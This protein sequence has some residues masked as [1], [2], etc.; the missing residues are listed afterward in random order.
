[1]LDLIKKLASLVTGIVHG[2][3]FGG[4]IS[5]G[6]SLITIPTHISL[7]IG[8]VFGLVAFVCHW[9]D[10]NLPA[11]KQ[12]ADRVEAIESKL[13]G[14][15][16]ITPW[17]D[18]AIPQLPPG[19]PISLPTADQIAQAIAAQTAIVATPIVPATTAVLSAAVVG[20]NGKTQ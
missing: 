9:I 12:I 1:M 11:D 20:A 2:G 17:T 7:V 4:I 13:A 14:W 8:G 10:A 5:L 19:P 16:K 15:L 3:T 18:P 6:L